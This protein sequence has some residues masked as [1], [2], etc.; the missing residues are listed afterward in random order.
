MRAATRMRKRGRAAA[1]WRTNVRLVGR[2]TVVRRWLHAAATSLVS[3]APAH[4][5]GV[6]GGSHCL[7]E[8]LIAESRKAL[9]ESQDVLLPIGAGRK[10]TSLRRRFCGDHPP[11]IGAYWARVVGDDGDFLQ[12]RKQQ[13][14]G[15]AVGAR[16]RDLRIGHRHGEHAFRIEPCTAWA[17]RRRIW[18]APQLQQCNWND[19]K[20][21]SQRDPG[22]EIVVPRES[23]GDACEY[24]EGRQAGKSDDE[25][26]DHEVA[27]RL[28]VAS[29]PSAEYIVRLFQM[30]G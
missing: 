23:V 1:L 13:S 5:L 20:S 30:L 28:A 4:E 25:Q 8:A 17:F 21:E 14:L 26:A 7:D 16:D 12:V 29:V 19:G 6:G 27:R 10:G 3:G 18:G 15:T 22:S 11:D 9:D 2:G 24:D